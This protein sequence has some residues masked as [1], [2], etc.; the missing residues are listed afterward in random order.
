MDV[1]FLK[2]VVDRYD[3]VLRVIRGNDGEILLTIRREE[4]QEIFDLYEPSPSLV[5]VD[6]NEQK[7]EY[8][9][10]KEFIRKSFLPMHLARAGSATY[11]IG[12]S[13]KELFPIGAFTLYFQTTFF[14]L[15]QVLGFSTI[16]IRPPDFM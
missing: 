1:D 5:P 7:A 16:T 12:P 15:Y 13:S 6:L 4:F 8:Y 3:P 14:S 10:M 2:A 9:K 11:H